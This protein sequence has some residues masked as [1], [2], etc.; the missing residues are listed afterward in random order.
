MSDPSVV[1]RPRR[2]PTG[3]EVSEAWVAFART[4]DPNR[5]L[6]EVARALRGSTP[7]AFNTDSQVAED[8]QRGPRIAMEGALKL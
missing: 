4:G 7:D 2:A 6:S 5:A 1:N 8:P 3:R